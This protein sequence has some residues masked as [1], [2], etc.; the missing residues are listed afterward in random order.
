[1]ADT[2]QAVVF[3]GKGDIRIEEVNVPKPG[4]KEVQLKPAFVGICGTDLHEYLEGAYLIPTTPHPVTGKSAPVIIGHEYSGVVSD[5][6][7][8]VDDLKPGDRVVVQPI[9]FD[10]SCNSC[11][12]GLINCCTNSGFIGLSGKQYRDKI[13]ED[14]T[15]D[16]ITGIGGGLATYTTVPRYSVFKIPDNIP[17]QVAALVEPLAVAWNAV[18][19]SDF[20]PGDTA[21]IL[22][23]GPIGL[24]I[25]QVLKSKGASQTIITEMAD[26]RR[27]FATKFG[28]TTV[29]DPTKT[30]VGEECKKLCAGEG[31]QV[32][33]D[34]AGVQSTLETALAASRPRA[35]IVNVAIWASEVTIS[36]NYF[37][38]NE[39]TFKGSATY[40]ASVFQEVIDALARGDLNPEPMITSLIDMEEIEEKGFK[41]LINYKDTQVKILAQLTD[42]VEQE[43]P[44]R[45]AF[46][47]QS[48][49]DLSGQIYIV[50]GGNAG[51][52]FNTVL[53]LAAHK[54]KVYM[55]A[56]S[57][58][59]ANAAISE[60]KCKYPDADISVLVMDMMNLKTVKAAADEFA[61]L[62]PIL[63]Q[64]ARSTSPGTVR[65]VNVSS[66]GHLLFSPSAG[67]DFD[68]INQTK[69][70]AFSRYGMSKLANILHAKELHRR[71]GPSP[72][73]DRQEEIWTA[74][75]HPGTIDTGLGRNATGSWAW[76]AL[77]P[78][79]RLFRLYSPLETAAYTS[80][81]AIAGLDFHRDMSGE[82]LKP[83]GIIGKTSSTAQD[84]KLAEELWRWTENE[85][86]IKG[87]I[88]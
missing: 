31:V 37:M 59:K 88:I 27:E 4:L 39:R 65:V 42:S 70:S 79:M 14:F 7:D 33:F 85:M 26:K 9:I 60:I 17:L 38:L 83:V 41:A 20:K 72:E 44:S 71:Y 87:L 28:A 74:S 66:D 16:I 12:R 68:D 25:L 78:V 52:G 18:Q 50:T 49:P 24:A 45:M 57:E 58:A 73:N 35:V 62:L 63:T 22:G 46:T 21:L 6:G 81:F 1:M 64:S 86:R 3:H 5:V 54:A 84:P 19:Q 43:S 61:R 30:N 80:L 48:L 56:R 2:M 23:A 76:Q 47:P 32:V 55:G 53:E 10:G 36:P 75:L 67:I 82:Y 77:V 15:P 11:Q 8:E 13:H 34:C 69:G 51:I 29:L 40:T